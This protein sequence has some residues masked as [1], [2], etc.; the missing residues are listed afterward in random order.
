MASRFRWILFSL[1]AGCAAHP[2]AVAPPHPAAVKPIVVAVEPAAAVKDPKASLLLDQIEPQ[3]SLTPSTS[4]AD[5]S[6]APPIESVRLFARSRIAMLDGRRADAADLLEQAI[7]LDPGSFEL[8]KSLGDLYSLASD[9]RGIEQWERAAELQPDRLDL[10]IHLGRHYLDQGELSKASE[11]L[12]LALLTTDYRQ[13]DPADGEADFLLARTLQQEGYDRAALEMYE[14]LLGRLQNASFGARMNAQLASLMAHPDLLSQHIAALYEKNEAYRPALALLRALGLREPT[15]FELQA[16]IVRDTAAA[17]DRQAAVHGAAELAARFHADRPSLDLLRE[18]AGKDGAQVLREMHRRDP[19]DRQLVYAL[20]DLLRSTGGLPEARKLLDDATRD[21]PDDV[22]VLRRRVEVLQAEKD[23][24]G[25]AAAV[26][27]ALARMPDHEFELAPIW[28]SLSRPAENGRLR[29]TDVEAIVVASPAEGARLL[30]LARTAE[31]AHRDALERDALRRAVDQRPVFAPAWREMLALIWG[32]SSRTITEKVT[33]SAILCADAGR[34]GNPELAAELR[35]QALLDEGKAE[36][37]AM[38]FA[39]AV[40]AGDRAPELYLNFA[41]VLHAISDDK[42][43]E[44]LLERVIHDRPLIADGYLE[45]YGLYSKLNEPEQARVVLNQWLAS[46]PDSITAQRLQA[47]EAMAR[48]QSQDAERLLLDLL[49]R[50]DSDPDVLAAVTRMYAETGRLA[51]LATKFRQRLFVEPWNFTLAVAL[52]EVCEQQTKIPEALRVL[53]GARAAAA[54]DADLLYSLSAVYSRLS[55]NGRS[56]RVLADVL[57]IDPGYA[58]AN[59]DLGYFW[60]DQGRNLAAAEELVAR[61][62]RS[63]PE[64]LSFLDSMGWVLYKRGKFQEALERLTR[65][66]NP[67]STADPVVLSHLGDTLYRL[68]DPKHAAV[69]WQEATRRLDEEPDNDRSDLKQLRT[70]LQKKR[71]QLEAGQAVTVSPVGEVA[72]Q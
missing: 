53:D 11:H 18:I 1:I 24:R 15:N 50:S 54:T 51:E 8:H 64:N 44:S 55:D 35:G 21:W 48:G 65:A 13:E 72:G 25:A 6:S 43:A 2:V 3:V 47:R 33:A 38:A 19:E 16:R 56:E 70:E 17:G 46:D 31:A 4:S 57:K 63:E 29:L 60:A 52:A 61:A 71:K 37:A 20:A 5:S 28:D 36:P 42:G 58:G 62:L 23:L 14:R 7:Q 40:K 68:G 66:A 67:L 22:R 27:S 10:Q 49:D 39:A 30:L 9:S 34:A 12:R 59:N 26:I 45:L 69:E 32:D 41:A